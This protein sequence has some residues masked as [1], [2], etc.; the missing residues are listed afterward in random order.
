MMM[1]LLIKMTMTIKLTMMMYVMFTVMVN[2]G[3]MNCSYKLHVKL[4]TI[5][6][7]SAGES[8]DALCN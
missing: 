4:L 2:N 7:R 6:N 8:V 5:D 1:M 3:M